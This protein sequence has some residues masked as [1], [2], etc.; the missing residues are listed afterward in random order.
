MTPLILFGPYFLMGLGCL[1]MLALAAGEIP[2]PKFI[3]KP[4]PPMWPEM[5]PDKEEDCD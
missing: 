4:S 1:Y 3:S 2:F 5:S